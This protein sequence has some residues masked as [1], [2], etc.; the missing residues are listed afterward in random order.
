MRHC[1]KRFLVWYSD[2]NVHDLEDVEWALWCRVVDARKYQVIPDQESWELER[3][4]K[5]GR[6]SLRVGIDATMD[7]E[8]REKLKRPVIPGADQVEL[9][10]YVAEVR[11]PLG[12]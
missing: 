12:R 2:T 1:A 3:C 8:D 4:A 9:A 10:D 7:L 11:P 5:P 6:G